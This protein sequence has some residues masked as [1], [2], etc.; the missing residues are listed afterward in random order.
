MCNGPFLSVSFSKKLIVRLKITLVPDL[1][2]IGLGLEWIWGFWTQN[3]GCSTRSKWLKSSKTA[4][5]PPYSWH[6]YKKTGPGR[7]EFF[8]FSRWI[9]VVIWLIQYQRGS[10]YTR[11][12]LDF[13]PK[14][15]KTLPKTCSALS[16]KSLFWSFEAY[17]WIVFGLLLAIFLCIQPGKYQTASWYEQGRAFNTTFAQKSQKPKKSHIIR[18]PGTGKILVLSF[19]SVASHSKAMQCDSME[20]PNN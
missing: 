15:S 4:F 12:G 9:F 19:C 10:F 1:G 13:E 7:S 11:C 6:L 16:R 8:S 5:F 14:W 2:T 20:I 17:F 3:Y 18:L